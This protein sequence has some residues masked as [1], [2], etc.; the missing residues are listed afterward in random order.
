[1][2]LLGNSVSVPVIQMIGEA[3]ISTGVF[4]TST[5]STILEESQV[6]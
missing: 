1:M 2:K 4:E 6:F 3:I 5:V